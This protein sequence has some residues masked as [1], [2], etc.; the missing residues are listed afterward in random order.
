MTTATQVDGEFYHAINP[1]T[2][3]VYLFKK[4]QALQ[5]PVFMGGAK[6]YLEG[7]IA[8]NM[9]IDLYLFWIGYSSHCF[10]HNLTTLFQ[11]HIAHFE[12]KPLCHVGCI[13]SF[14]VLSQ[15]I[16]SSHKM[17][18]VWNRES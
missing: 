5:N 3:S 18:I 15:T 14:G 6:K 13:F 12:T 2:T 9:R 16:P 4:L 17:L 10:F 7:R 11:M 1:E 8:N